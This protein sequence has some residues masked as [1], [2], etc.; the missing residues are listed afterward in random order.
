MSRKIQTALT[1]F[2]QKSIIG[3]QQ[4]PTLVSVDVMARWDVDSE[5]GLVIGSEAAVDATSCVV[6]TDVSY[7]PPAGSA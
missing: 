5:N 1:A 4:A 7:T 3:S 6:Q 2:V